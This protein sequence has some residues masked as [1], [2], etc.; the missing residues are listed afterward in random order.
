MDT[1]TIKTNTYSLREAYNFETEKR[2]ALFCVDASDAKMVPT[3]ATPGTLRVLTH[4][5]GVAVMVFTVD[6]F[7]TGFITRSGLEMSQ[8]T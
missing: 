8:Y 6:D 4:S 7:L 3:P 5:E 1:P 2:A